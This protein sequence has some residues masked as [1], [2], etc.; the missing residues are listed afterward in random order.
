MSGYMQ[1]Q[2]SKKI[3]AT[4]KFLN[5]Q[6]NMLKDLSLHTTVQI[7]PRESLGVWNPSTDVP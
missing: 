1:H 4:V 5:Q 6:L 3:E 7:Y 2:D